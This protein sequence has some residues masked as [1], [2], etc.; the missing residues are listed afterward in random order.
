M[1]SYYEDRM[2]RRFNTEYP[3]QPY[4]CVCVCILSKIYDITIII[5]IGKYAFG[6]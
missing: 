3:V 6:V 5:R 1:W 4:V 2:R